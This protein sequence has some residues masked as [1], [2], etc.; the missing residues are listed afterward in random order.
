MARLLTRGFESGSLTTEVDIIGSTPLTNTGF[1]RTGLYKLYTNS[2]S[3]TAAWNFP[4]TD[5]IYMG[6]G[7]Y[8]DD[9]PTNNNQDFLMLSSTDSNISLRA[10]T[11][12]TISLVRAG[13]GLG[14]SSPITFTLDTWHYLE[15]WVFMANASGRVVVKM[16][17]NTIIDFT[18]DTLSGSDANMIKLTLKG[19]QSIDI[20]FD[21]VVVNDDAGSVNNTWPGIISL[22]PVFPD[23]AGANT[24]LTRGGTDSGNNWNQ[25]D[26][27]P[28]S[29]ADYVYGTV[30]DDYDLY[31]LED[32]TLPAGAAIA[33]IIVQGRAQLDS[34]AGNIAIML[35]AGTTESDGSDEV[36]SAAWALFDILRDVN[37]DDSLAWEEADVDALQ[38]GMK[39]R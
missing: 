8:I 33:N 11:N 39:V 31:N 36:L 5:N 3:D 37:P 19:Q 18:G 4:A 35:K 20:Y 7:F 30:A 28:S 23:S 6:F 34:G 21:D 22:E 2:T 17:G 10:Y 1:P 9:L 16:D 25:V 24:D 29:A 32:F 13:S 27:Q 12:S 14:T 38:I 26:E 15:L